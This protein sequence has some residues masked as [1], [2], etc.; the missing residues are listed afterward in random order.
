GI[1]EVQDK[2]GEEL[3]SAGMAGYL[4]EGTL[5]S[6]VES[7]RNYSVDGVFDDDVCVLGLELRKSCDKDTAS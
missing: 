4:E 7:A 2:N 6:L 1:Y 5:E 3:G